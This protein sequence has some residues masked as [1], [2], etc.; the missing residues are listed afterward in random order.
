V[1]DDEERRWSLEAARA[2][3]PDVVSRTGEAVEVVEALMERREALEQGSTEDAL[4]EQEIE[5]CFSRWVREME[6]LGV[7]VKGPWLVDFD[8]GAGYFCWR[9]PE[10]ELLYFHGYDE[11]FEGRARIQ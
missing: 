6:A 10:R 1:S 11:G 2:M 7:E 4:L 9:W 3:L 8:S 5:A